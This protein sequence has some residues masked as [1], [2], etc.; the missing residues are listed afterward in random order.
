MLL[1]CT[2]IDEQPG[3]F[4]TYPCFAPFDYGYGSSP[5]SNIT[6]KLTVTDPEN[7]TGTDTVTITV[8]VPG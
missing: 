1:L 2:N 4:T 7:L 6:L 8:G 5:A 3:K